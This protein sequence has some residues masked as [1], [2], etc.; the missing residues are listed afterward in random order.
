MTKLL[1]LPSR[2][3]S[4]PS[5]GIMQPYQAGFFESVRDGARQ[6]AFEI[7][8][9]VLELVNPKSVVDVGCGDGTWLSVFKDYGVDHLLGIDGD[10][11]DPQS[12]QIPAELFLASDLRESL[13]LGRVFDMAVS[14]EVA[15]HLPVHCAATFVD[16]LV[17]LA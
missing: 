17:K 10:Y 11:V 9:T 13:I 7:V 14:L 8:P 15:E 12:L 16:S 3:A 6:S 5:E 1:Q 2:R 4:K